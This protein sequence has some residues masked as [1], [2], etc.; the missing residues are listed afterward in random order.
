MVGFVCISRSSILLFESFTDLLSPFSRTRNL[1]T[2]KID[3][4]KVDVLDAVRVEIHYHNN[5]TTIAMPGTP[6]HEASE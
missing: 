6:A 2:S 4:S 1:Q 3:T 5:G